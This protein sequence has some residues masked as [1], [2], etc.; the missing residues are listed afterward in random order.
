MRLSVCFV[1]CFVLFGLFMASN[2]K[3]QVKPLPGQVQAEQDTTQ[4]QKSLNILLQQ[5]EI[6]G[7]VEKP[8]MVY[9]VPGTN[10][11]IDDI[12]L[13]RSFIDEILRPLDKDK[14]EKQQILTQKNVIPW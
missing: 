6:R 13:E 1:V 9:V 5:M 14:F 2:V 7:W 10:P 4:K 11:K 12:V 3:A 8:Q